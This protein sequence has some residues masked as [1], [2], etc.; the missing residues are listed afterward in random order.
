MKLSEEEKACVHDFVKSVAQSD[1]A[2]IHITPTGKKRM[3]ET[4]L[5]FM[6][7]KKRREVTKLVN[8]LVKD[9]NAG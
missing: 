8:R 4:L 7:E 1:V 5:G 2:K 6:V 3:V 9:L